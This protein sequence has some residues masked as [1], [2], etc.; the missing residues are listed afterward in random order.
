[1]KLAFRVEIK[2]F[3]L[4]FGKELNSNYRKKLDDILEFVEDYSKRLSRPI[5]DLEDVRQAMNALAVIREN[6]IHID[7][8]LGPIEVRHI[9]IVLASTG[10]LFAKYY[11]MLCIINYNL[12]L[13]LITSNNGA[14]EHFMKTNLES[15]L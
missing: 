5:R 2:E 4:L 14:S 10:N 13:E 3:K 8:S 11:E 6:Q 15:T 9:D 1:L 7:M 12:T